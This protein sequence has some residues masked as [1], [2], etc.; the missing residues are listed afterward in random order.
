MNK[1]DSIS[2]ANIDVIL[3]KNYIIRKLKFLS[4]L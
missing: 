3:H 2:L 1:T 4:Q